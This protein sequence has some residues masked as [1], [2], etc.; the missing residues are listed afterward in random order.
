MKKF[1]ALLFTGIICMG[2][3]SSIFAA[4]T[5][6]KAKEQIQSSYNQ[7]IKNC[8]SGVNSC[9]QQ[10]ENKRDTSINSLDKA[11][12]GDAPGGTKYNADT[13]T[14]IPDP[15]GDG[16]CDDLLA[17]NKQSLGSFIGD[18][19]PGIEETYVWREMIPQI[20]KIVLNIA[21]GLAVLMLVYSGMLFLTAGGD[22][23]QS[24][25]A[26]Q[27]ITFSLIGILVITLSRAIVAIVENLPL[28]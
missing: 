15:L 14:R 2:I 13:A 23:E 11:T 16:L 22:E 6:D 28:G 25:K 8:G 26:I 19:K 17:C 4:G 1:F 18:L 21:G 12:P 9:L 20:I 27:T 3:S 10:C 24:S 5:L 7:C